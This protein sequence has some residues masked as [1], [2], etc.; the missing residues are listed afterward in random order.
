MKPKEKNKKK[1]KDNKAKK[2]KAMDS[3]MDMD[4]KGEVEQTE[5]AAVTSIPGGEMDL[6]D[7]WADWKDGSGWEPVLSPLLPK[8][9]A[10]LSLSTW[11]CHTTTLIP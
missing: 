5:D 11:M 8:R 9:S 7:R 10:E 4:G 6:D 1:N 3:M 2:K